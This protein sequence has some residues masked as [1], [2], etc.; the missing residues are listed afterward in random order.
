MV[1]ALI[2]AGTVSEDGLSV[3]TESEC[4]VGRLIRSLEGRGFD[5]FIVDAMKD[6]FW[7]CLYPFLSSLISVPI[8]S[9]I[10]N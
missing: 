5:S 9:I 10:P 8:V 7:I 3:G 4:S 2:L 6:C 1:K